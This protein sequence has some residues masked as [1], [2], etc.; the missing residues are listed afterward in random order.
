MTRATYDVRGNMT[1]SAIG[2]D[3]TGADDTGADDLAA[4]ESGA[5]AEEV[6]SPNNN[7]GSGCDAAPSSTALVLPCLRKKGRRPRKGDSTA[8]RPKP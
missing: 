6:S 2:T 5:I 1:A 4:E 3:D 7:E 8:V